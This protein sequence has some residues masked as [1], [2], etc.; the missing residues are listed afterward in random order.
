MTHT[1]SKTHTLLPIQEIAQKIALLPDEYEAIGPY[2]A[3]L[4]L[5]L[6]ENPAFPVRGKFVL[7]TRMFRSRRERDLWWRLRAT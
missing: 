5:S 4:K 3:K 7:V 1:G 6:L 2:G